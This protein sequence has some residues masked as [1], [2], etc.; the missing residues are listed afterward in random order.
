MIVRDTLTARVHVDP[1]F[2]ADEVQPKLER[3][4]RSAVEDIGGFLSDDGLPSFHY[5][6]DRTVDHPG[7]RWIMRGYWSPSLD[8]GVEFIG[9]PHDGQITPISTPLDPH[10]RPVQRIELPLPNRP[11]AVYHLAGISSEH[12]RWVYEWSCESDE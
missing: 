5:A 4:L 8:R 3:T 1:M 12:D 7:G 11:T 6:E 9:G 10:G 2:G